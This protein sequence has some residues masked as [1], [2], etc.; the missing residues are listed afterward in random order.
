VQ[1]PAA[2]TD[3]SMLTSSIP[4][5]FV[6]MKSIYDERCG[7]IP[8]KLPS[9]PT[10]QPESPAADLPHVCTSRGLHRHGHSRDL[11]LLGPSVLR[12]QTHRPAKSSSKRVVGEAGHLSE[13]RRLYVRTSKSTI[14]MRTNHRFQKRDSIAKKKEKKFYMLFLLAN[15]SPYSLLLPHWHAQ[16][17]S[18]SI[19]SLNEKEPPLMTFTLSRN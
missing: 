19:L 12:G 6:Q 1:T 18:N 15:V 8:E 7:D 16:L 11:H 9:V 2:L 17:V 3:H 13:C 10:F 5:T 4:G 14:H